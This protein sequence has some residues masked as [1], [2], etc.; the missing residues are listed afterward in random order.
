MTDNTKPQWR[1]VENQKDANGNGFTV[2]PAGQI[3]VCS[4]CGKTSINIYCGPRG[5]DVS[6]SLHAVLCYDVGGSLET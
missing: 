3:F 1:A 4:A 2:A 6:C 5:W